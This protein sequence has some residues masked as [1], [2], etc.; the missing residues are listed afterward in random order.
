[1]AEEKE[2]P[3]DKPIQDIIN[4]NHRKTNIEIITAVLVILLLS[5]L[6]NGI[7]NT[8]S[9]KGIN[10]KNIFSG[11][12]KSLTPKGIKLLGTR[13]LASVLNPINGRVL[14]SNEKGTTVYDAAGGRKIGSH[15]QG[16]YGRVLKGPV[17][18]NG[19]K[20]FFV[21]FETGIDG[22]VKESDLNY[23]D[24]DIR[25]LK[26]TDPLGSNVLTQ[27]GTS[28]LDS[29]G[30]KSIGSQGK[31]AKGII[32]KG[33]IEKDGK[34]YWFVDF[35]NDPDGFVEESKLSL[36]SDGTRHLSSKDG[37]GSQ[38]VS[39]RDNVGLYDENG[40][41]LGTVENGTHGKITK[42]PIY[43]DGEKYWFVEYENG[44]SG[45]VREDDLRI[46]TKRE[47]SAGE[48]I[49]TVFSIIVLAIKYLF[50]ILCFMLLIWIFRLVQTLT[51][52]RKNV[53]EKLFP[54]DITSATEKTQNTK[55]Q[56]VMT[57]IESVNEGDWKLAIL[58]A[59]I[60]LDEMLTVMGLHGESIGD[61]LKAVE[62]SDFL[63]IDFAWEAHKVRNKIAHNGSDF[64][65]TQREARR[66]VGL[67]GEVFKEF[68]LI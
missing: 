34:R 22:W 67:Y 65:L 5:M 41:I 43:I 11:G 52:I 61:K 57:H 33:P 50:V 47:K 66:V 31:G 40:N 2:K 44:L 26:S 17:T 39:S 7:A 46:L 58:E 60:M 6:L 36:Y 10:L 23:R 32:T 1:M 15:S 19:E 48:K 8:L 35:E 3:K 38:V 27:S 24:P 21:D 20:Y 64:V 54:K 29:P 30:G 13:P 12:W 18:V 37:V 68:G 45:F 51:Q 28:V 25:P 59:D 55:W 56:R 14:V 42:G 63:N 4:E 49:A 62:R 9:T 53:K 16:D